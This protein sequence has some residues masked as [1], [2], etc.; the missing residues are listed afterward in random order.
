MPSK[1]DNYESRRKGGSFMADFESFLAE[2]E[3]LFPSSEYLDIVGDFLESY[4][5]GDFEDAYYQLAETSPLRE[6]LPCDEWVARREKW[7]KEAQPARLRIAFVNDTDD[8]DELEE[9]L[10]DENPSDDQPIVEA[11][12][13]LQFAETPL[14][15]NL[16]EMPKATA[17]FKET[18]R[19]WFW[20]RFSL[21]EEDGEWF[22][23]QMVDE[24]AK[25]L[26]LQTEEIQDRLDTIT[27]LATE[28]IQEFG[29]VDSFLEDDEDDDFDE[30]E[31]EDEDEVDEE[32]FMDTL[33]EMEEAFRVM[34]KGAHYN[35][36]LIAHEP[37]EDAEPYLQNVRQCLVTHDMERAAIYLQQL[38]QRFPE[39]KQEAQEQLG[40]AYYSIAMSYEDEDTE[41]SEEEEQ[42]K[43]QSQRFK[44]LAEQ[45]LRTAIEEDKSRVA[46]IALSKM[47]FAEER[48]DEA[49]TLLH[50]VQQLTSDPQELA[51]IEVGLALIA[52]RRDQLEQSL[53][54]FQRVVELNPDYEALWLNIGTLQSK[55]GRYDEAIVSLRRNIKN[56]PEQIAAY[57]ELAAIYCKQDQLAKARQVLQEGLEWDDEEPDL[58]AELAIVYIQ[59]NDLRAAQKY[60]QQAEN[61][62][63]NHER[64]VEARA[65]LKA[66][67]EEQR[68]PS[69]RPNQQL[70]IN[71]HSKHNHQ[72]PNKNKKKK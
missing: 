63:E 37:E 14:T 22:I 19:R 26:G 6:G 66:R 32:E 4:A 15:A 47:F 68:L 64:V 48:I 40:F 16:P 20:A 41:D 46:Y 21:T 38:A 53:N 18:G 5:D 23:D 35:D 65:L 28:R 7:Q 57:T 72:A 12:W 10:T 55:L 51:D 24:G 62:D 39:Q 30:D 59:G 3:E 25:A 36:A 34:T 58:L 54:H 1:Y 71:K 60:L 33:L 11:G 45:T 69:N 27:E 17:T 13:S 50:E 42:Y 44:D 9:E 43:K 49:E 61:I 67:R 31:D 56:N 52:K 29:E 70:A 8:M 2:A